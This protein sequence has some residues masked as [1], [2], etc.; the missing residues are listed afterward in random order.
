MLIG[1]YLIGENMRF[2]LS[3]C[4]PTYNRGKFL[5]ELFES[6]LCQIDKNN[7]E[8]IE[9]T[10]SDNA[11][12][13]NTE[14]IVNI[15]KNKFKN[16]VYFKWDKNMGADRNYL[17]CV[18]IA[19]GE[20]CWLMGSDDK[21]E[22]G[23]I[24]YIIK[25][26]NENKNLAGFSV[27]RITYDYCL[28]NK[29]K[30]RPIAFGKFNSD[31]IFNNIDEI[32]YYLGDYFG[33]ISGQ[34][35]HKRLWNEVV[36]TNKNKIEEYYNAYVH[37]FVILKMIKENTNW[38]YISKQYVVCRSYNDSF[39]S[40]G[41]LN[42]IELDIFGYEKIVGD[43]IGRK[44]VGYLKLME[45]IST[46]QVFNGILTG[47]MGGK[48]NFEDYL[49]L[50]KISTKCYYKYPKFWYKTFILLITPTFVLKFLRFLYRKTIKKIMVKENE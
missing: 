17:K 12:T 49:R 24:N 42:R 14:E 50:V 8:L 25:K 46:F 16:F 18:E 34:I 20:F 23:G 2:K 3:I 33:Y 11:S 22:K 43:V 39:L 19:N 47:K 31:V 40:N 28:K 44:S 27:N 7:E 15:Y 32:V 41:L 45:K 4:I 29:L 10:V 37:I 35:V 6:I 48:L 9:V 26:I 1:I 30:E 36:E 21:I 13:D 38:G 5:V